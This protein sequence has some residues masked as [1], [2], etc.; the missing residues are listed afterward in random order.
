VKPNRYRYVLSFPRSQL[1]ESTAVEFSK[2]TVSDIPGLAELMLSAY[3]ET[4]DDDDE[5]HEDA[6]HEVRSFFRNHPMLDHSIFLTAGNDYTAAC[7]V[8]YL[9]NENAPLIAYI[10]TRRGSK[11]TGLARSLLETVLMLLEASGHSRV[12]ATISEGN[13]PSERL[14][15]SCG[16]ERVGRNTN[17]ADTFNENAE[18]YGKYR[19]GYPGTIRDR[20]V[21]VIEPHEGCR[22]LE[23]GCGTGQA[24][25]FFQEYS[26]AQTCIDPGVNLLQVCGQR[27]PGYEYVCT[28]FEDYDGKPAVFDLIYAAT[29]FHWVEKGLRFI[30]SAN[31]LKNGA[32]LSVLTDRHTKN[33]KGFFTEVHE[34]YQTIAPDMR[35]T[36]GSETTNEIEKNPL[37][38]VLEFETDRLLEYSAEQYIGLLKTFSGHIAL[39]SDRLD[40]LCSK[41]VD[42]IERHYEG[43]V[44]KTM[45]TLT[46]IYK[47]A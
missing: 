9:D 42:L 12:L 6:E 13:V 30:K 4:I 22:I 10:M 33:M 28:S 26:P 8:S 5:T 14:F 40:L 31:L 20:I 1:P 41:I 43:K 17:L 2:P 34:V 11:G 15:T 39:G 27:F 47:N 35:Y 21:D 29:S 36:F 44:E 46:S 7:L 32:H 19:P 45:T 25:G 24:T 16:F 38:L 18:G 3:Q 37:S 23:V